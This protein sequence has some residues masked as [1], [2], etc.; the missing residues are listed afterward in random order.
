MLDRP[1]IKAWPPE[2]IDLVKDDPRA[3]TVQT[4]VLLHA[5]RNLNGDTHVVGCRVGDW[6]DSDLSALCSVRPGLLDRQNYCAGSVLLPFDQ[7]LFCFFVPKVEYET[8]SPTRGSGN[9]PTMTTQGLFL[10]VV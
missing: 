10:F 8:T 7:S 9:P 1:Q 5:Q 3:F 4:Q 2:D 6:G